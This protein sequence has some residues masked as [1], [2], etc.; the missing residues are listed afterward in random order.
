MQI[1][2][3]DRVGIESGLRLDGAYIV[4]SIHDPDQRPARIQRDG[5][6]REILELSFHDAEASWKDNIAPMTAAQA[7]QICDFVRRYEAQVG[8]IVVQCEQG[9]SRSP[10]VAAAIS[11][12]L[13]LDSRRF[14]QLYT[15]SQH[16]Y[17]LVMDAFERKGA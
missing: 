16:V 10:A 8:T 17:H 12:A 4:I 3:T 5:G 1:V 7:N 14:F 2:V 9:M 11:Q 13:G 6:L 15:P